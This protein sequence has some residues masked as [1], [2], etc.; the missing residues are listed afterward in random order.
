MTLKWDYHSYRDGDIEK[1]ILAAEELAS[2][3]YYIFRMGIN[4]IKPSRSSNPKIID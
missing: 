1:Y 2:R 3:G 4:V